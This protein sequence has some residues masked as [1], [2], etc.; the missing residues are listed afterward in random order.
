VYLSRKLRGNHPPVEPLYTEDDVHGLMRLFE[1]CPFDEW[2][3]IGKNNEIRLRF[4]PAGHILGSAITELEL[5]DAGDRKR[6]VFTGDLGRRGM[7]L[8][9]D[10]TLI[11]E[12][13]DVVICESTYGNRLHSSPEDM[14]AL[15]L[16]I[17]VETSRKNGKIVIPSFAL[18]RTQQVVFH[19]NNLF[20]AGQLPRLPIYVDS[21]LA[22]RLTKLFRA[23]S[24][25]LNAD[26]Q[27]VLKSDSDPFGFEQLTYI[28][29]PQESAELNRRAGP[30]VVISASGM[31]E[32]GRVVHHLKHS[33]SDPL[34]TVLLM[35]YQA[36]HTLGRQ[37][38][39]HREYVRIFD[40]E[41][42][43]LAQVRQLDGLSAHADA[44]DFKWWFE[45]STRHGHFGQLFLVHGEPESAQALGQLVR[46][47]IDEEPVAPQYGESFEI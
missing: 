20:N 1:P 40:H 38:A 19:L 28:G 47:C 6:V 18:G 27:N 15:L 13:A 9:R 37:L 21:P 14:Q 43:L 35:G 23:H 24:R 39:E 22:T 42:P 26:V 7:P 33:V 36:P 3:A 2:H 5:Q 32:S 4:H 12:G 44:N 10:P 31:C 30:F 11:T 46:H 29:S 34:N 8:L 25:E 17:M 16:Q 41:Q 45:E